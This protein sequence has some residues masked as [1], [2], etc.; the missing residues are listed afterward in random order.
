MITDGNLLNS[1]LATMQ[2]AFQT[3]Q[4]QLLLIGVQL[5]GVLAVLQCFYLAVEAAT[6]HDLP[7]MLEN[8][9][10]A[11]IKLGMV[12]LILNHVFDWGQAIID[13]GIY[14]GRTVSGQSPNV[15]TPSGVFQL[16]LNLVGV[17]TSAKASGGF[18]HPVQDIEW[19]VTIATVAFVWLFA[20]L[21]YLLLLIEAV[22]AVVIGPIFVALGGLESTGDALYGWAKTL[23]AIAVSIAVLLLTVAAGMVLAQNWAL[24]LQ[25]NAGA[26]TTN[27]TYLI[28]TA[29]Q[30]VTFFYVVK[31]V[32]AMSQGMIGRA[33]SGFAGSAVGG[34]GAA[35][36]GALSAATGLFSSNNSNSIGDGAQGSAGRIG[37]VSPP[38]PG[39][40]TASDKQL[41]GIEDASTAPTAP[42]ANP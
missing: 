11:L 15:L 3:Y 31:H 17:L 8:F 2:A 27:I 34:L 20:A 22:I 35:A 26:L 29:A 21:L 10:V 9:S 13:T 18:L 16:G 6:T 23:V 42:L 1:L 39:A 36:G 32:A 7:H 12:Y 14:I 37:T 28:L 19:A 40:L 38:N 4:A 24:Q 33:M 5:L 41:L 25:A 30:S